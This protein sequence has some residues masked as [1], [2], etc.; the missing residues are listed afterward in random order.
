MIQ[1]I[2]LFNAFISALPQREAMM[3]EPEQEGKQT[4][5]NHLPPNRSQGAEF[6]AEDNLGV[7]RSSETRSS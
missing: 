7:G 1:Q 6:G 2:T 5:K 4:R 3:A